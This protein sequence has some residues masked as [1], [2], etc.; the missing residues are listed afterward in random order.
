M[1]LESQEKE[2]T[3]TWGMILEIWGQEI[4][5]GHQAVYVHEEQAKEESSPYH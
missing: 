5:A 3:G 4:E 1:A 2:E